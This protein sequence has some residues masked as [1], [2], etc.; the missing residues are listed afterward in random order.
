MRVL[1]LYNYEQTPFIVITKHISYTYRMLS[2]GPLAI[3][4]LLILKSDNADKLLAI[5]FLNYR[6]PYDS[7][8]IFYG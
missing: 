7:R 3:T 1:L 4:L 8:S 6:I 2:S 5:F